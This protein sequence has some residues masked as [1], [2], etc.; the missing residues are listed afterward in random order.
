MNRG[1]S[2]NGI[3][4]A[5]VKWDMFKKPILVV[6]EGNCSTKVASFN[7]FETAE[8]FEEK[9]LKFFEGLYEEKKE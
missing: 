4:I 1:L 2:K 5:I 9:V 8:W 6:Q 7:S 3:T